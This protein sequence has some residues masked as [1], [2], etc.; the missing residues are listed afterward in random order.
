MT[1]MVESQKM[2]HLMPHLTGLQCISRD[3]LGL[4]IETT[5]DQK[6]D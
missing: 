1:I 6:V 5:E 4:K 3:N 2:R